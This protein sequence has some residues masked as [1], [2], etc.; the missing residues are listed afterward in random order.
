MPVVASSG[1]FLAAVQIFVKRG[2]GKAL[3]VNKV[4]LTLLLTILVR[5]SE[6]MDFKVYK[7]I[8]I[9]WVECLGTIVDGDDL[10]FSIF[11]SQLDK[12]MSTVFVFVSDGVVSKDLNLSN[13]YALARSFKKIESEIRANGK[14]VIAHV[15]NFCDSG[16]ITQFAHFVNRTIGPKA[17][18][19]FHSPALCRGSVCSP[20]SGLREYYLKNMVEAGGISA[21]WVRYNYNIFT[22]IEIT[23]LNGYQLFETNSGMIIHPSHVLEIEDLF[24]ILLPPRENEK[25]EYPNHYSDSICVLKKPLK[26]WKPRWAGKGEYE[27]GDIVKLEKGAQLKKMTRSLYIKGASE[28]VSEWK[29]LYN[30][31]LKKIDHM[32]AEGGDDVIYVNENDCI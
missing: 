32:A 3:K 2:L 4:L 10:K 17:T 7:T 6:A 31:S 1:H 24:R 30:P 23:S 19:G 5:P 29:I 14:Y 16:C 12:N 18:I 25:R 21:D 8:G 27:K 26:L 28:H 11:S 9:Q 20:N 15:R 13:N 22:T